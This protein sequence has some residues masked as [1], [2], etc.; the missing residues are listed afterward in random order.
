M[1][2]GNDLETIWAGLGGQELLENVL[3]EY[4]VV[5]RERETGIILP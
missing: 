4:F 3:L 1:S 2:M 5:L